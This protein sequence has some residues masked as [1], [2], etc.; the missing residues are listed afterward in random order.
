[1]PFTILDTETGQQLIFD[2]VLDERFDQPAAPTQHPIADGN[3]VS[4]HVQVGNQMIFVRALLGRSPYLNTPGEIS[5]QRM[6]KAVEFLRDCLG[7]RLTVTTTKRG[8]FTNCVLLRA[9]FTDDLVDRHVYDLEFQQVQIASI[10]TVILAPLAR[11]EGGSDNSSDSGEQATET[12]DS[13]TD[14]NLTSKLFNLTGGR[15]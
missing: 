8:T 7:H 13:E 6:Q 15:K 3:E 14:S 2:T 5:P 10:G 4:D 1:M 12:T 9:P 11:V